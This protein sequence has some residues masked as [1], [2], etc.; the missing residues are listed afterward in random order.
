MKFHA[1]AVLGTGLNIAILTLR[2]QSETRYFHGIDARLIGVTIFNSTV[3]NYPTHLLVSTLVSIIELKMSMGIHALECY[4]SG[5]LPV[6]SLPLLLEVRGGATS[7]KVVP[8][9]R[10][11]FC[12]CR[13][14]FFFSLSPRNHN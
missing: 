5:L 11:L 7:S 14:F 2:G 3:M 1:M 4:A 12:C 8:P 6:P 13:L 10:H 9:L